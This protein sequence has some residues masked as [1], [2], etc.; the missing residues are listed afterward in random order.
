MKTHVFGILIWSLVAFAL[1]IVVT[2]IGWVPIVSRQQ[3]TA[4]TKIC[5]VI[6]GILTAPFIW[7]P[8]QSFLD[9]PQ[10]FLLM[11][12]FWGVVFY[13]FHAFL[14]SYRASICRR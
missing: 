14:R 8:P 11:F 9:G 1:Y 2:A 10:A 7:I 6:S 13:C 4:L 5:G 12:L 3:E